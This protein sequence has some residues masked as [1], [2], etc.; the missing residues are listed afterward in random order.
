MPDGHPSG[1]MHWSR[2]AQVHGLATLPV[3]HPNSEPQQ[4]G[5]A[6]S[7]EMCAAFH[8]FTGSYLQ[9]AMDLWGM[10]AEPTFLRPGPEGN[11]DAFLVPS[12]SQE[13]LP[14]LS[15]LTVTIL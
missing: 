11:P 8:H 2:E 15:Y 5:M 4:L 14:T 3:G 1:H 6:C 7:V 12:R 9:I 13:W 10:W